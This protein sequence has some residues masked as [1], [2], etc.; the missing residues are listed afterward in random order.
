MRFF[1]VRLEGLGVLSFDPPLLMINRKI[2]VLAKPLGIENSV[3]VF[4]FCGK[5]LPSFEVVAV[6]AHAI[7]IVGLLGV[8]AVRDPLPVLL[9]ILLP[10]L[11]FIPV[12]LIPA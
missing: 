3:G 1:Q 2:A 12:L 7:G 4:A 5:L 10:H 9:R 6:L 8:G 11:N